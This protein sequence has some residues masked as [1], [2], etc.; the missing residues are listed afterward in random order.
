MQI[1]FINVEMVTHV[2]L[3]LLVLMMYHVQS[4]LMPE[5]DKAARAA[6]QENSVH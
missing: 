5:Q 2:M 3:Q 4:I 6:L 1:N